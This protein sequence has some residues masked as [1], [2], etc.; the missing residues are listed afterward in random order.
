MSK[1]F[2]LHAL[3]ICWVLGM[4]IIQGCTLTGERFVPE[5]TRQ[6]IALAYVT[7][8]ALSRSVQQ[9]Y[10]AGLITQQQGQDAHQRLTEADAALDAASA[11]TSGGE[12]ETKLS[13]AQTAL[14]A[15]SAILKGLEHE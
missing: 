3:W 13:T 5:T 6:S 11:A 1:L 2:N 7:E 10:A 9:A 15:V 12:A 14:M 8:K 4:A